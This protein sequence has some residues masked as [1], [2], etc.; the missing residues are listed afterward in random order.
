MAEVRTAAE[1]RAARRRAHWEAR[2]ARQV[3]ERGDAGRADAWW[4]RCR[5]ICKADPEA[6]RDLAL[7]LENWAAR[8]SR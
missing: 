2:Q 5:A 3:Q 8:Q 4:D 1:E 7:T 6:W